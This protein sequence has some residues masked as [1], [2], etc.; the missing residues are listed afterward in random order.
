MNEF[1]F[2]TTLSIP[3]VQ[4]ILLM[5]ISTMSLLFGKVRLALLANFIFTFY[6][7]YFFN[8]D[9][10]WGMGPEKFEYFTIIYFLTG[11]VILMVAIF[12]FL[13]QKQN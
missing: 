1:L 12:G 5:T 7:A 8:R 9:L 3:L 13:F 4:L 6:W 2:N 11:F 10:L